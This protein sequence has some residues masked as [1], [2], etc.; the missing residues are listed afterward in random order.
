MSINVVP[1]KEARATV[2]AG[3]IT[4]VPRRGAN[5]VEGAISVASF[6]ERR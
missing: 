3:E 1:V 6:R 4:C 5:A 2:G